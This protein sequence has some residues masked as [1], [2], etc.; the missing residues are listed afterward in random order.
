MMVASSPAVVVL[1]GC[2][3]LVVATTSGSKLATG[4]TGN[5]FT[6]SFLVKFKRSVEPQQA[7]QI[8]ERNGFIN[9]GV[10][11]VCFVVSSYDD[12]L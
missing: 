8:A 12:I 5:V 9:L 7:H 4:G 11:S 6:S 3:C 1:L 2:Y 10:V